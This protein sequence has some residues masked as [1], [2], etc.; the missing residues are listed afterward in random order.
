LKRG[1]A[2]EILPAVHDFFPVVNSRIIVETGENGHRWSQVGSSPARKVVEYSRV[3]AVIDV[4]LLEFFF[5][6]S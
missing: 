2:L 6:V 1:G 5:L 4:E 3:C